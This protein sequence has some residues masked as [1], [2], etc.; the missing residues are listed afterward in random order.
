MAL[1]ANRRHCYTC[2]SVNFIHRMSRIDGDNNAA[3]KEIAITRRETFGR[4]PLLINDQTRICF[5]C[6]VSILNEITAIENDPTCL[7]LNVLTQ[8]SS[9]SCAICDAVENLQRLT[10][11]CRVNVFVIKNIYISESV[12]VCQQHL[13]ENGM[14]IR[15]L[16]A[17]L[18]FVNRPYVIKGP[19]LLAFLQ[20]L[21]TM[22]NTEKWKYHDINSFTDEEFKYMCPISKDQFRELYDYC[23]P[24]PREGGHDYVSKKDL[25]V[26]LCKLKQGLSDNFLKVIFDYSSRQSTSYVIAKVRKSLM[27]RFVPENI[28]LQSITRQQYIEQHVTDFANKLYN[29]EP[30]EKKAIAYIDGTYCSIGKSSNFQALRQSYCVHKGRHLIKPALI[31]APD[32]YI[33]AIHGPYFSDSRNN[34]SSMLRNEMERDRNG[35]RNWFLENDI[36]VVDRGYRDA[37]PLLEELGIHHKIP[38]NIRTGETQLSTEEAN[39]S[40]LITKTRWIIE[41]RNGHF[42]S[43]FKFFT[44]VIP[45][46]HAIHLSDFYHICGAII[47][48]FRQSINMEG[49]NIEFANQLLERARLPNT[50]QEIVLGE[51]LHRRRGR[52]VNLEANYIDDFPRLNLEY[53]RDITV[54]TYQLKLAPSYIQDTTQREGI[55]LQID[56]TLEQ[57]SIIRLRIYSRHRNATKYQLWIQYS[58][59]GDPITGYYCTCKS[60][61]RTIGTCSHVASVLWFLGYSRHEPNVKYPSTMLLQSIQDASD[62]YR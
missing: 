44:D 49:A 58:N 18:R 22:N 11:Q 51:N 5:N 19:Q 36:F 26:F 35:I 6:N 4:P 34:D 2:H 9:H 48:R 8:T 38:Y 37:V 47:N 31:V 14:L 39:E 50:V 60:G 55:D 32:G 24:V 20:E 53:L 21:R 59:I 57:R 13:D 16:M 40:R 45:M 23:E 12:R 56:L 41:S 42:K 25:L 3:K 10:I 28:G 29:N 54:G 52:W 15:Q 17:G 33:L 27:Q 1:P 43:M 62:R 30:D 46:Q 61:A 7:R